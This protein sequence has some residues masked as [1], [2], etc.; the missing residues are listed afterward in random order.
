MVSRKPRSLV[1]MTQIVISCAARPIEDV[2]DTALHH[3]EI[4][5]VKNRT[6]Y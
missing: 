2:V 6:K 3:I 5:G 4:P 1:Q